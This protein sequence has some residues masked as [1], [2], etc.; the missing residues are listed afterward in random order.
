MQLGYLPRLTV[1][2]TSAHTMGQIY[3]PAINWLLLAG[4]VLLVL[5]FQTSSN[6]AAAYGIAVS[7]AMAID[8]VLAGIVARSVWGWRP[9]LVVAVFGAFLVDRPHAFSPPTR[10]RCSRAAGFRSSWL[11][12]CSS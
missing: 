8:A 10:S 3:I 1:R 2:H 11:P 4:V 12:W 7:A 6:L 5:G 9:A